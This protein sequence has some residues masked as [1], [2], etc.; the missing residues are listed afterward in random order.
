MRVLMFLLGIAVLA[1]CTG[2][3]ECPDV[4]T[5]VLECPQGYAPTNRRLWM[6]PPMCQY[7]L[8]CMRIH[9]QP[10]AEEE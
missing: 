1:S 3:S 5:A 10:K 4:A 8:S 7:Q 6:S 2:Q 9:V